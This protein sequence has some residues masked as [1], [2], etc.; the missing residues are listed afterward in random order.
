[1]VAEPASLAQGFGRGSLAT[2]FRQY[3]QYGYWKVELMRKHGRVISLR[4]VVPAVF[5]VGAALSVAA[6][7]QL[8][9]PSF[10]I[11]VSL[12]LPAPVSSLSRAFSD[13]L[14]ARPS[15][16]RWARRSTCSA[17]RSPVGRTTR[18]PIMTAR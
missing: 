1:M 13:A 10:V 7:A 15:F 14:P 2:L 12:P 8:R 11:N 17:M 6:A 18:S 16:C 4:H 9:G 5:V 3:L